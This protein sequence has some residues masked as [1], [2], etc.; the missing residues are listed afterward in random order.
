MRTPGQGTQSPG[1]STGS[2]A[3]TSPGAVSARVVRTLRPGEPSGALFRFAGRSPREPRA[4]P[5]VVYLGT[6]P[7]SLEL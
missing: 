5:D 6:L 2:F 4:L 3:H 7:K 1:E